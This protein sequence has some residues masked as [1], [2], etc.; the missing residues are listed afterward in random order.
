MRS[1]TPAGETSGTVIFQ[2]LGFYSPR[3]AD[4][5]STLKPS[6]V[7]S[8]SVLNIPAGSEF[9]AA[10]SPRVSETHGCASRQSAADGS[11]EL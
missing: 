2:V 3:Q 4:S 6:V 5:L 8:F 11:V 10:L 1:P 9:C 7:I